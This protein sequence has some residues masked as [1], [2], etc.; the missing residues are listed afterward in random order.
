[1]PE[2]SQES[3]SFPLGHI[4]RSYL[5]CA[6]QTGWLIPV[7]TVLAVI[8][9][10][11]QAAVPAALG[12][13]VDG[14][15]DDPQ[16]FVA[17]RLG[18]MAVLT[19]IG[20]VVFYGIAYAQHYLAQ[21]IGNTVGVRFRMQLY[22]HLQTLSADFYQ[23]RR[24]GDITARLT[25]D[26]NVG[27]IPFYHRYISIVWALAVLIPSC[28]AMIYVDTVLLFLFLGMTGLLLLL[29]RVVMPKVRRLNRQVQDEAGRINARAT[30]DITTAS[31]T[32]AFVREREARCAMGRHNEHF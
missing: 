22:R 32:R 2:Q 19:G 20:I 31:L 11:M 12:Y 28:I 25:N 18:P 23:R 24:V 4:A 13:I 5:R 27:V 26:I 6:G 29:S 3:R 8:D 7:Q 30:E 21:K 1:M 10:I 14:L 16:A 9:G 15:V 17:N